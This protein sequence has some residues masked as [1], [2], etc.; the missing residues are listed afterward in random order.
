MKTTPEKKPKKRKTN[1]EREDKL[2][3]WSK[4]EKT[5]PKER[6]HENR[7]G[8][9]AKKTKTNTERERQTYKLGHERKDKIERKSRQTQK[10]EH[11]R[12]DATEIEDKA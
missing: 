6:M 5:E 12:K 10:L 3:N 9:E 11:E 4:R 8:R 7:T 1:T 2:T